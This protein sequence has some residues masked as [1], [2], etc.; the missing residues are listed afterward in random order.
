MRNLTEFYRAV[1]VE[2]FQLHK[3]NVINFL[4]LQIMFNLSYKNFSCSIPLLSMPWILTDT[5]AILQIACNIDWTTWLMVL[6]PDKHL[7]KEVN[8]GLKDT[9]YKNQNELLQVARY[10]CYYLLYN[11]GWKDT[12]IKCLQEHC[13]YYMFR[14]FHHYYVRKNW[15]EETLCVMINIELRKFVCIVCNSFI[16]TS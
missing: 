7:R 8:R 16:K 2:F 1:R 14:L 11:P 15:I 13:V 10:K 4:Q 12:M 5:D 6:T 3:L 9:N